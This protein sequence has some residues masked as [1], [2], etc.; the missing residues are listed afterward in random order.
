MIP[1]FRLCVVFVLLMCFAVVSYAGTDPLRKEL[2][3]LEVMPGASAQWIAKRMALN[4]LSMSIR[5]FTYSGLG[6]D[7]KKFYLNRWKAKGY[8]TATEQLLGFDT[9][10]GF[11]QRGFYYTVQFYEEN[12]LVRGKLTVSKVPSSSTFKRQKTDFPLPPGAKLVKKIQFLDHGR[13]TETLTVEARRSVSSV[14]GYID[15]A[16]VEDGWFLASKPMKKNDKSF[17]FIQVEYARRA[18][19]LQVTLYPQ[20]GKNGRVTEVH[21][22]W[23]NKQ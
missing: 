16:L 18:E 17:E 2:P 3:L 8:G 1:F 11:E 6:E 13:R 15:G 7:V 12:G 20:P 22:N 10:L 4:G 23:V 5:E 21:I 9:I 14:F 19:Q